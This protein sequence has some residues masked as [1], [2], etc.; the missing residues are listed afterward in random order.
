[1]HRVLPAVALVACLTL[2]V[3][4]GAQADEMNAGVAPASA[5]SATITTYPS[6]G[7]VPMAGTTTYTS[8]TATYSTGYYHPG[9]AAP[10]AY[11][12]GYHPHGWSSHQAWYCHCRSGLFGRGGFLGTG[13][14]R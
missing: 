9:Y 7:Y 8:P 11:G 3:A 13:L 10:A 4:G 1:M 12:Y 5:P 14:F 2:L 6:T